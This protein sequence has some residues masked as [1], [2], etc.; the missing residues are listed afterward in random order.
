MAE[1]EQ[2]NVAKIVISL[3]VLAVCIFGA[4]MA[5]KTAAYGIILPYLWKIIGF[6]MEVA[7]RMATAI[8]NDVG[9][10]IAFLIAALISGM[11]LI[12]KLG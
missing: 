9:T 2:G 3:L 6:D 8:S 5:A 7:L 10:S 12:K 1:T 11:Y 4:G